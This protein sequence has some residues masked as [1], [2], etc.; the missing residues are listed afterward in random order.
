M[1][2]DQK[3][4]ETALSALGEQLE[5]IAREP[6]ELLACGGS[7]L[8][9]LG[10]IQRATKDVDIVAYVR[11]DERGDPTFMKAD[12]LNPELLL[13]ARKVAR[14]FNLPD[15][16]LNAGPASAL[17]FGLPEGLLGRVV[18]RQFGTKLIVHFLG[19]YDQICFKVYAATDQGPGKHL[20]DLLLLKPT[21][22]EIEQ[23]ARWSMSHD[24]SE[25]YRQ[26]LRD[27]LEYIGF[28][29]VAQRL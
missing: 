19:R 24:S 16:W 9:V 17:D 4:V 21:A 14:D 1:F 18:T 29:D 28:G 15:N 26:S 12:P 27:L 20:D 13:A 7:A 8:Q 2:R 5:G 23:A 22:D 10:L 25:G 11:R 3:Q 6:F